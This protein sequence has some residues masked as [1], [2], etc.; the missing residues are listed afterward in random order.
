VA[1]KVDKRPPVAVG[2]VWVPVKDVAETNAFLQTLGL[3]GV[4]ERETFAVLELRGGTH[5]I[6]EKSRKRI[7]QGDQA[8]VDFMVDD[9][10]QARA[11]YAEMGLKPTR[12]KSGSVHDSFFIPGPDG[13][14]YKI[15]SSHATDLPV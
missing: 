9:I 10:K 2:H 3:R 8:P 13:W 14:F 11:T 5:L 1:R 4:V 12:I 6:I 15:T 7:K